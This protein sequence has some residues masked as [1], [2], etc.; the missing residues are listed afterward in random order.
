MFDAHAK[1]N[2]L[3]DVIFVSN[4]WIYMNKTI[5]YKEIIKC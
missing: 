3:I 5:V 1:A 2:F 4:V